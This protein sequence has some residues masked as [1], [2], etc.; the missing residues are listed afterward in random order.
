[1]QRLLAREITDYMQHRGWRVSTMPGEVNIV[2]L[3]GSNMHGEPIR[4]TPD[5][6]ND[7]RIVIVHDMAGDPH[8]VLNVEATSEPGWA[9]TVSSAARRRGG[10]ARVKIG[11]YQSHWQVGYHR[12][13]SHP[14]LIDVSE[15]YVHRDA[16]RD[17]F[18]TGDAVAPAVGI[19]QHGTRPGWKGAVVGMWSEGCLV[20]RFWDEHVAFI[21]LVKADPR[22]LA[23]PEFAFD[24]TIIDTSHFARWRRHRSEPV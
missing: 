12:S 7:R 18:R 5:R 9:A 1:M 21:Y 14:A 22:Y 13:G 17:G 23:D 10:V 6:F 4:D 15:T 8:V 11:Q 20:G 3:E 19:N 24:T 16:N 2:Y